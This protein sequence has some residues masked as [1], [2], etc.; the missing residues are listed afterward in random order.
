M[1]NIVTTIGFALAALR[2]F[3]IRI[4]YEEE[5]LLILFGD[6]YAD[7]L[8]TTYI[9]IPFVTSGITRW[10]REGAQPTGS[11]VTATSTSTNSKKE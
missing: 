3:Q 6:E 10:Q 11:D 8:S 1:C 4:P 2:F 5:T 7:Y 9:G